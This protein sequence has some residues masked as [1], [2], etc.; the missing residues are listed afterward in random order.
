MCLIF[1]AK[2][3]LVPTFP[4]FLVYEFT[5]LLIHPRYLLELELEL[6]LE[7]ELELLSDGINCA[8]TQTGWFSQTGYHDRH[9][10]NPR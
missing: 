3:L 7:F 6:E 5:H 10:S 1:S 8:E 2:N 9:G 4:A